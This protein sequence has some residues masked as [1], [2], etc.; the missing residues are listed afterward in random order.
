MSGQARGRGRST[1]RGAGGGGGRGGGAPRG[2]GSAPR[3]RGG[4]PRG[5]GGAP[6]GRGG[7]RGSGRGRGRGR[8]GAPKFD[9]RPKREHDSIAADDAP[10]DDS[11]D[12]DGSVQSDV[13]SE[14][15]SEDEKTTTTV[16]PYNALLES[17]VASKSRED[18]HK[19]KR[20]KT[21]T[22]ELVIED[23]DSDVDAVVEEEAAEGAEE[24]AEDDID[25]E[26]EDTSDPFETH[27]AN[28]SPDYLKRVDLAKKGQWTSNKLQIPGIG[29]AIHTTP[30][31]SEPSTSRKFEGIKSLPLKQRL[32]ASFGEVN[33]E[34]TPIQK[35]FSPYIFSHQ[36]VL[37][38][39]RTV[40]NADE[41]RRLYC[42]HALNHVWKTRDR[43]IKDN[44]KL[45]HGGDSGLEL[46]DQGFTRPK[47]LFILPT[48]HSCARVVDT[49]V[50]LVGAEQ[51]ENKKRF[52]D[53]FVVSPDEDRLNESKPL[54]FKE[55]FSGNHDDLFRVGVKFTRKTIKFF[56][57][58]YNSDI[59]LASPLGLRLAIGDEGDK[60]RDFDF[61]SSIELVIVDQAD[62]LLQ[63][64]WDHVGHVF[65]HLNLI[66]TEAHGCDFGRVRNWYLDSNARYFRQSLVFSAHGSP[67]L[68]A[69][70]NQHMTN[71]A[72]RLKTQPEY[73]G[74]ITD[75]GGLQVRQT[76]V[77]YESSNPV[78]DPNARFKFFKTAF[79]PTI[80]RKVAQGSNGVLIFIAS[81]F[82]FVRVRN[83]FDTLDISFGAISEE[84]PV[85]D[86]SRARSHFLSGRFP[87]LL[88]TGRAHHFRRYE[89]RGVKE[90]V[91]YSLPDNQTFYREVVGGFLTRSVGEGRI[92]GS[93]CKAR[94]LFSKWDAMRLER[95]VGSQRVRTM[96]NDVSGDTFEFI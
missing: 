29:R 17:L 69:L 65:Q 24:E 43:V 36:D 37:F 87:I 88:Y 96:C 47:I 34:L 32:V 64:N 86:V 92:E 10:S 94:V 83:F 13:E 54:D 52:T 45:S 63:Q 72:G 75:L 78:A 59:I 81:Y 15:E 31:E 8:G 77:R 6:G 26:D 79:V 23:V 71:I 39:G 58:F 74:V 57:Q 28:P 16:K 20:R 41:L 80:T 21:A 22:E 76:F 90:V 19:S 1:F 55:L 44:T 33:G 95:V 14:A 42:I 93:R 82:D 56:S 66:P 27:F 25:S 7:I 89:I 70:F 49:L 2:R 46:R 40:S 62:S 4:A 60:K 85:A 9:N 38:A 61:L 3:G 30:S 11:E 67:E 53:T 18:K 48:R 68:N 51:Q 73:E 12:D 84:T 5:R 91:F 35:A 50:S